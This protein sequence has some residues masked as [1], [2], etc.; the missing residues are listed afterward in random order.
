VPHYILFKEEFP[1]TISGKV[2]K[3]VMKDKTIEELNLAG[4]ERK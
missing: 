3:Y 1:L 2:L 4:Q